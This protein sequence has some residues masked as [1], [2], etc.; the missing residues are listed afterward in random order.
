MR[1]IQGAPNTRQLPFQN[2]TGAQGSTPST[3]SGPGRNNAEPV[4]RRWD[5]L[6]FSRVGLAANAVFRNA[7][8]FE[9]K[10]SAPELTQRIVLLNNL[11][12][13]QDNTRQ[14]IPEGSKLLDLKDVYQL[15]GG[16]YN[17]S[18]GTGTFTGTGIKVSVLERPDNKLIVAF[19]NDDVTNSNDEKKA[20]ALVKGLLNKYPEHKIVLTGCGTGATLASKSMETLRDVS[21]LSCNVFQTTV[22]KA[23]TTVYLDNKLEDYARQLGNIS[24]EAYSDGVNEHNANL[25]E[26]NKGLP[27]SKQNNGYHPLFTR[28]PYDG[29]AAKA[30]GVAGA[31]LG[32]LF[33]PN[34]VVGAAVGVVAGYFSG[35]A[36]ASNINSYFE[37]RGVTKKFE[38]LKQVERCEKLLN[39][40]E[41]SYDVEGQTMPAGF[42]A[43]DPDQIPLAFRDHRYNVVKGIFT[44]IDTGNKISILKDKSSGDLVI[45]FA[46]TDDNMGDPRMTKNWKENVYQELNGVGDSTPAYSQA[47][48][49]FEALLKTNATNTKFT[50]TGHSLGGG[51]AQLVMTTASAQEAINQGKLKATVFNAVGLSAKTI[52]PIPLEV[53]HVASKQT[54]HV[55][56]AHDPLS[57][58]AQKPT[59]SLLSG[60]VI[61]FETYVIHA[62]NASYLE[63]HGFVALRLGL[64]SAIK[65]LKA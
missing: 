35:A 46:G 6:L 37:G 5:I 24:E 3:V 53:L 48:T 16:N 27:L 17:I 60:T 23:E 14:S 57:R 45:A 21:L 58:I 42:V 64:D 31:T 51:L 52:K 8:H 11:K 38:D 44:D 25:R 18:K 22:K 62:P 28:G 33:G 65:E 61:T 40:A 59:A 9:A 26:T 32:F 50:V 41:H 7:C 54:S 12:H 34:A 19:A 10:L 47:S 56:I 15:L 29:Y 55:A 39:V 2:M 30:I 36:V 4:G 20:N 63:A 13:A 1:V 49:L 43:A